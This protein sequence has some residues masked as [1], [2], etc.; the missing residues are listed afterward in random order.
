MKHELIRLINK[1][2]FRFAGVAMVG[3]ILYLILFV[4][5]NWLGI[6]KTSS[7]IPSGIISILFNSYAHAR[8]SFKT[9]FNLGF[10]SLY[11]TIQICCVLITYL[12][13]FFL[14]SI[15]MTTFS[16]GLATLIIWSILSFSL[17]N[18]FLDLRK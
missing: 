15:G 11:L 13:S 9:S 5:F 6:S 16:I 17:M 18:L 12:I 2:I 14:V 3:E 7:I 10:F 4:F 1:R 8:F